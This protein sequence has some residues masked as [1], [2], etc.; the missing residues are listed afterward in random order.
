MEK[1]KRQKDLSKIFPPQVFKSN[2]CHCHDVSLSLFAHLNSH[3]NQLFPESIFPCYLVLFLFAKHFLFRAVFLILLPV[4]IYVA[5][6]PIHFAILTKSGPGDRFHSSLFQS[7][8]EDNYHYDKK[9]DVL[10]RNNAVI[11]LRTMYGHPN[12]YLHSH[13]DLLPQGAGGWHQ[14]VGCYVHLDDNNRSVHNCIEICCKCAFL[15]YFYGIY[16]Q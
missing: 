2:Y 1:R 11:T 4:L 13:W 12:K 3:V 16:H 14:Q 10:V 5:Q 15:N 6:Y 7:T 9:T 8:L